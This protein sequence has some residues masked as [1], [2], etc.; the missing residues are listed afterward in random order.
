MGFSGAKPSDQ[1]EVLTVI[2]GL[3][4]TDLGVACLVKVACF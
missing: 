4:F 3:V 2:S 1:R